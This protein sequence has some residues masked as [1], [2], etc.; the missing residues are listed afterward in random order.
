[1]STKYGVNLVLMSLKFVVISGGWE[2]SAT[3]VS[4]FGKGK[5]GYL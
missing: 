4:V 2:I 5:F 1:M 3:G